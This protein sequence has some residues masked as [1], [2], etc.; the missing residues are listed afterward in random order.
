MAE[1][2]QKLEAK[3]QVEEAKKKEVV[4]KVKN[5]EINVVRGLLDR[6]C[7]CACVEGRGD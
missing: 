6:I 4:D 3:R 1:W 5:D 2:E 7:V